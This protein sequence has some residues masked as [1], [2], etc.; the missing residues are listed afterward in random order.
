MTDNQFNTTTEVYPDSPYVTTQ[1][2][3]DA[4]VAAIVG[5]TQPILSRY[6]KNE[7]H[8]AKKELIDKVINALG[9]QPLISFKKVS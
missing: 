9:Y 1:Q 2:C 4:Q 8:G 3:N 5:V 6:E 7:Y